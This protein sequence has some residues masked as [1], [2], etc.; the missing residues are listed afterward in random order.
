MNDRQKNRYR[1]VIRVLMIVV[2]AVL[3]QRKEANA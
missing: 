1:R 2:A 3:M